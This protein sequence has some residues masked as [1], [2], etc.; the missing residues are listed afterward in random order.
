[1]ND[2]LRLKFTLTSLTKFLSRTWVAPNVSVS[3]EKLD[4]QIVLSE[5]PS[6]RTFE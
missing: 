5:E 1:M 6:P 4:V 2:S 3:V